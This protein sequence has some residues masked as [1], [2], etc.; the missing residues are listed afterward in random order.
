MSFNLT[1]SV[2]M[3]DPEISVK[4][5]KNNIFKQRN[6]FYEQK[7]KKKARRTEAFLFSH[8]Q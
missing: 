3:D 4:F 5:F 1:R 7:D 8:F 6:L 2:F